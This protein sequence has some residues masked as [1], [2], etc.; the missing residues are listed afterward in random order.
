L[1]VPIPLLPGA[2]L[3]HGRRRPATTTHNQRA[4]D[5]NRATR[6]SFGCGSA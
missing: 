2:N 5:A 4:N 6:E 1:T 3:R